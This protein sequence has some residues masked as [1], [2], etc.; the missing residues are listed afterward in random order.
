M[1]QTREKNPFHFGN[2]KDI[3]CFWVAIAVAPIMIL[4]I[5]IKRLK[6][7][8]GSSLYESIPTHPWQKCRRLL[9]LVSN[10][11]IYEQKHTKSTPSRMF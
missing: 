7:P 9:L 4:L 6:Q 5:Q 8:S 2:D 3:L 11:K 10:G 1:K